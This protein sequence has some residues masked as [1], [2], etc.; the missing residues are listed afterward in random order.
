MQKGRGFWAWLDRVTTPSPR[1]W[2]VF[3][4]ALWAAGTIGLLLM[5]SALTSSGF[6]RA[7]VLAF[8]TQTAFILLIGGAVLLALALVDTVP[9]RV[10]VPL[11]LALPF[12]VLMVFPIWGMPRGLVPGLALPLAIAIAAGATAAALAPG[13]SN[14]GRIFPAVLAVAGATAALVILVQVMTANDA[15]NPAYAD[16]ALADRTLDLP[17][18]GLPGTYAVRQFSY[19]S[20]EDRHRAAY[21]ADIDW[22][23]RRVD[24]R[25]LLDG[26]EDWAGRARSDFWGFG[27]DA[28]PLQGRV[29]APEGAGPF[30]LVLIVHGNHSMEDFSD[31]GYAYLGEH[32]ASHGYILVSVDEN[33]LNSSWGDDIDPRGGGLEEEN[34]ARGW[35][36]LE[37]LTAWA[38]WAATPDHP[39]YAR[40]DMG[41]IG[42]IGHSRGGEAVATA[43]AFNPLA[44]YPDDATLTFDYGFDIGAV[45]AIAPVDGQY[46]PRRVDR[47]LK[48]VNYFVIHG[49]EDGDVDT[50]LGA[51]QFQRTAVSSEPFRFKASLYVAGANH[52]Q[53]NTG[54]GRTDAPMPWALF[55]DK[56]WIMA[57]ED[58]RRI[59]KIYFTAV[60]EAG[61]SGRTEWLALLRDPTA[62]AAWLPKTIYVADYVDSRSQIVAG[63]EEDL[64]PLT[65][66]G[67]RITATHLTR[68][69]ETMLALKSGD[70]DTQAVELAWDRT[71]QDK[72]AAYA[73]VL[74]RPLDASGPDAAI[75]FVAAQSETDTTPKDWQP[76]DVDDDA[77]TDADPAATATDEDKPAVPEPLDWTVELT[78]SAGRSARAPLS[79]DQPLYPLIRSR[80][81]RWKALSDRADREVVLRRFALPVTAFTDRDADFDPARV[82]AIRFVFDRSAKGAIFVDAIG[83]HPGDA[84]VRGA[85]QITPAP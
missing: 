78:D 69:S 49:S 1:A 29:W 20:G 26:W 45:I 35:L 50:F 75:R 17:D 2:R 3:A 25:K 83:I 30:P 36:L 24:G 31:P 12:F 62:G 47:P 63:Y 84:A 9:K 70:L 32:L 57:G 82:Q 40:V 43:A 56:Q 21:G 61:L 18:P 41:R 72:T 27:P 4:H 46:Q 8:L 34:D 52:G 66:T 77:K 10:R 19:G 38:D 58:Q 68:W 60:L 23:A 74:D 16:Y 14:S 80:P 59:A 71:V 5:A 6:A 73:V 42:L 67:G 64:D 13:R 11:V 81:V 22:P 79:T 55:L 37:H 44:A 76:P 53:F 65:A 7:P 85:Q 15:P 39:F 54:W 33:F 51:A 28:L 48:D